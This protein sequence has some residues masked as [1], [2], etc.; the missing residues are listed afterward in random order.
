MTGVAGSGGYYISCNSDY[1]YADPATITG[2]IGV[3]GI[4]F[5]A[6]ELFDKIHVNWST[7]KK[8]KNS[9]FGNF[10][11][12]W[13]NDEKDIMQR[14]I[15]SSYSDFVSKVAKG[16]NR[17]FAQIDSVAQGKIWTGTQAK[18][19]GLIDDLGGLKEAIA[20][21]KQLANINHDVELV[22]FSKSGN[23]V[24]LSVGLSAQALLFPSIYQNPV[25]S[26]YIQLY[27]NWQAYGTEK[28]LFLSEMDLEQL[29][30]N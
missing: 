18:E 25:V 14:L 3:I 21:V 6:E 26:K 30:N 24:E 28:T 1:I 23:S 17:E 9:D 15:A 19:I 20:K 16:R 7:V 27:D 4:A 29:T 12:K 10:S 5:N 8:G 11:R 2:S 13:T 22:N